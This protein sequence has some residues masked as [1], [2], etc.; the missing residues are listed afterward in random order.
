MISALHLI[1]L[2]PLSAIV[3]YLMAIL[4]V[5][6]ERADKNLYSGGQDEDTDI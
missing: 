2:L 1:W 6:S 5:A 3:G 4:M